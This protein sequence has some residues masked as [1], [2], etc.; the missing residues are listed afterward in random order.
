MKKVEMGHSAKN[1]ITGIEGIVT[2]RSETLNGTIQ[3]CVTPEGVTPD[4]KPHEIKWMDEAL[5]VGTD[6]NAM[7]AH[8]LTK[9]NIVL[10]TTV[11]H[12]SGFRG[13]A[14]ERIEYINGCVYIGVM[15]KTDDPNKMPEIQY[16]PCQYL[17]VHAEETL[18]ESDSDGNGGPS[19]HAPTM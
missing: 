2:A 15:P 9:T 1:I 13:I 12:F 19:S 10:G 16:T 3:F 7:V 4:G 6:A 5:L 11:E 14:L 18:V 17:T 8:E